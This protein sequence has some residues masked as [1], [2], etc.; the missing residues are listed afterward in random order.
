VGVEPA[1][2]S[3]G[4][5][6]FSQ[7]LQWATSFALWF[8]QAR[9]CV[10]SAAAAPD[11]ACTLAP[12]RDELTE[13][14]NSTTSECT[15]SSA[16]RTGGRDEQM[17][18]C[19]RERDSNISLASASSL[20]SGDRDNMKHK[21]NFTLFQQRIPVSKAAHSNQNSVS[22]AE[23]RRSHTDQPVGV[24]TILP[25]PTSSSSGD[26]DSN[27]SKKCGNVRI[28]VHAVPEQ[29]EDNVVDSPLHRCLSSPAGRKACHLHAAANGDRWVTLPLCRGAYCRVGYHSTESDGQAA[30]GI[31][32]SYSLDKLPGHLPRAEATLGWLP[33]EL[34]GKVVAKL[35]PNSLPLVSRASKQ[36]R[37]LAGARGR[38]LHVRQVACSV[39]LLEWATDEQGLPLCPAVT[40]AAARS[41]SLSSVRWCVEHGAGWDANTSV[42][43][44][45]GGRL[46]VC[47]WLW[48]H[49][50]PVDH[51]VAAAAAAVGNLPLL[52][53]MHRLGL[54]WTSETTTAAANHGHTTVLAWACRQGCPLSSKAIEGA[55][56]AGHLEVVRWLVSFGAPRGARACAMAASGGHLRVLQFLRAY[57]C[58]WNADTCAEAAG[59]GHLEVLQWAH[60]NGCP[61]NAY[62]AICAAASGHLRVLKW[63]RAAGAPWSERCSNAAAWG[64]HLHVLEWL[65]TQG[66][67]W[68]PRTCMRAAQQGH[69]RVLQYL[70]AHGCPWDESTA[71]AAAG[72]GHAAVLAW[73]ARVCPAFIGVAT[74]AEAAKGQHPKVLQL[75][76]GAEYR[77]GT[78]RQTSGDPLRPF[79]SR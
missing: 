52:E 10:S 55:S 16:D 62:T 69:L 26:D 38:V 34:L 56:A 70:R 35:D 46:P 19:L 7:G 33:T 48:R 78:V 9:R 66:T 8:T 36:L 22:A 37:S 29:D 71:A 73:V 75:L 1:A 24:R 27:S 74:L 13:V 25:S 76:W 39:G 77:V 2:R 41:G 58:P 14:S 3:R 47:H 20:P 79:H 15:G 67:P 18:Q 42:E 5:R 31:P 53:N 54:P 28:L 68:G 6:P 11:E 61:W 4:R 43:A 21:A 44:A 12:R 57:D 59:E 32:T 49:G 23:E 50:C 72:A 64:G 65:R 45:L 63:V 30:P 60:A 17:L 51:R 40:N